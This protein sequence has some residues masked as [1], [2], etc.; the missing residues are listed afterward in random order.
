MGVLVV[1]QRSYKGVTMFADVETASLGDEAGSPGGTPCQQL[2][3][4]RISTLMLMPH[5]FLREDYS[6]RSRLLSALEE[7][8][9]FLLQST[10]L[11]QFTVT[12][13]PKITAGFG[14]GNVNVEHRTDKPR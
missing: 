14:I 8:L 5:T 6:S 4:V 10:F 11:A 13:W 3:R 2:A 7:V 1:V 9:G 12:E